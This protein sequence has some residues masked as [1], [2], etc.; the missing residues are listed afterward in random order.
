MYMYYIVSYL[1]KINVLNS[2]KQTHYATFVCT[3]VCTYVYICKYVLICFA[4]EKT[5][6]TAFFCAL[7]SQL[8]M[9]GK[10]ILHLYSPSE[11]E[12]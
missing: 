1:F 8:V 11:N 2:F 5:L 3:Y 12:Y 7:C 6:L 4:R 9:F 10:L